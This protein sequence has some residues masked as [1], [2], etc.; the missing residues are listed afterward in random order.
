V[1]LKRNLQRSNP[2]LL[3]IDKEEKNQGTR[4]GRGRG[5][6]KSQQKIERERLKDEQ[7]TNVKGKTAYSS[8]ALRKVVWGTVG[9]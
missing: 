3:E 1:I 4:S 9:P 6:R 7:T 5:K 8:R 2:Y